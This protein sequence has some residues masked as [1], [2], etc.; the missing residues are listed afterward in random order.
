MIGTR[1]LALAQAISIYEG[2]HYD[3]PNTPATNEESVAFRLNNPGNLRLSPFAIGK[4]N[5]FAYFVNEQIGMFALIWDLFQ[6]CNGNTSSGLTPQSTLSDLIRVWAPPSENNT[7]Q[8]LEFIEN[9]T[10]LSRFTKLEEM[11]QY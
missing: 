11:L 5:G 3:N 6:K 9:K 7:N 4:K 1:L 8:Y 10:G 2:W